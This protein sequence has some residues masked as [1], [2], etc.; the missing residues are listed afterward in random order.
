MN[1]AT[2]P[3]PFLHKTGSILQMMENGAFPIKIMKSLEG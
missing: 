1:I 2:E 3:S